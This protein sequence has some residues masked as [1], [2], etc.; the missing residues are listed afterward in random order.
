MYPGNE[1]YLNSVREEV[2]YQT[3]R[4]RHHPSLAIWCGNNE[5][6]EGWDRWGWK[7]GL[8]ETEVDAVSDSYHE[9][10]NELL[11]NA[12]TKYDDAPFWESSPMW[13]WRFK[14]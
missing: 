8:S 14:F 1:E 13:A 6:S 9:L 11:P 3:Q 4:L 5:V 2:Q 10:F 12:V 7:N